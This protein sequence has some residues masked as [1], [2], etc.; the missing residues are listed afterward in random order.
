M[1]EILQKFQSL[2]S[3]CSEN[4]RICPL[5]Q[6]WNKLYGKLPNRTQVGSGWN[7]SLPLI[8]GAWYES[9]DEDKAARFIEHLAWARDNNYL[10]DFDRLVRKIKEDDWHHL[11]D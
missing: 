6:I 5:P 1:T 8:L 4:E 9:S 3:Y 2:V 10:D 11:N 7:P